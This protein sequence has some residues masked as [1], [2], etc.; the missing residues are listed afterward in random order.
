MHW[1]A[2]CGSTSAANPLAMTRTAI[3]FI[4]GTSGRAPRKSPTYR[5]HTRTVIRVTLDDKPR[6]LVVPE[7]LD[8]WHGKIAYEIE[9]GTE[10]CTLVLNQGVNVEL[11]SSAL[12]TLQWTL[13]ATWAQE[14]DIQF[15][16]GEG[17]KIG[18]VSIKYSGH[19]GFDVT[20]HLAGNN[21]YRIDHHQ[22]VLILDE[23]DAVPG[24]D[25]QTLRAHFKALADRK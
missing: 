10:P 3:R 24:T 8:S 15:V 13:L 4:C 20:L 11:K 6:T 18:E 23:V 17:L 12:K 19:A 9:A 22:Q 16:R 7:L 14:S 2:R 21:R 25:A 1:P 5:P